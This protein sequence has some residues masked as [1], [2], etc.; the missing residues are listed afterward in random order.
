MILIVKPEDE[1]WSG[2]SAGV[3]E[4]GVTRFVRIV[5]ACK[6]PED[7][8]DYEMHFHIYPNRTPKKT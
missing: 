7:Q 4:I 8:P 1:K 3:H 6:T 5:E 2:L